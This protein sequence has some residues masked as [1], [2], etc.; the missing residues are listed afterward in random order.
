MR[1]VVKLVLVLAFVAVVPVTVSGVSSVIVAKDAVAATAAA[2]LEAEARHYAELAET[3]ILGSLDDL[4]QASLLGL[5]GLAP[6]ERRGALWMI[7]RADA[8]RTA[9]ALFDGSSRDVVVAPVFQETVGNDAGLVDHE[10]FPSSALAP[11]AQHVPLDEALA[12][13][14]AVGVPYVDAER[15][16]PFIVLAVRVPGPRVVGSD[17]VVVEAPWVV[18]VELSLRR[19]DE[20]FV[21]ARDEGLRAALVDL[22]GRAV[23][24]TDRA[25]MLARAS[26]T[27]SPGVIAMFSPEQPASGVA[28]LDDDAHGAGD[29]DVL[30]AWARIGRLTGA[31]ER[32][33]GVVVERDRAVALAAVTQLQN[34]VVFFVGVA[35]FV[36]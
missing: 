10:A 9:V 22:D 8:A 16:A 32:S 12:A 15:G 35:L 28:N 2:A 17:G 31:R 30:V 21:E 5:D 13:G 33:W 26:L 19:L 36:A 27:S 6:A 1:L 7:Y 24:H 14:K 23:C 3:T 11:F 20:R 25:R 34:R 4:K 18:A 29:D